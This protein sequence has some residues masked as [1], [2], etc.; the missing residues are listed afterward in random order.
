MTGWLLH[1]VM[2]NPQGPGERDQVG[3]KPSLHQETP[4][5]FSGSS[6]VC[7]VFLVKSKEKFFSCN[8]PIFIAWAQIQ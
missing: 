5:L 3:Q 1:C 8:Q 6:E 4:L 7:Q 2:G